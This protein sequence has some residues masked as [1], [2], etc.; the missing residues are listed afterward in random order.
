MHASPVYISHILPVYIYKHVSPV[1]I[2]YILL[3]YIYMHVS[4][5]YISSIL[6]VYIHKHVSPVYVSYILLLYIY[7]HVP[8]VYISS[9]RNS[10]LKFCSR[11]LNICCGLRMRQ[12]SEHTRPFITRVIRT[13]RKRCIFAHGFWLRNRSVIVLLSA[14]DNIK[15]GV[16]CDTQLL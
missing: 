9:S 3:S 16:L 13:T 15:N 1:Y 7:M 8:P 11:E 6:P 5:L 2:S 4:L 14:E 10:M 12:K